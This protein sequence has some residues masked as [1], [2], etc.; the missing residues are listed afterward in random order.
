[1]IGLA[2]DANLLPSPRIRFILQSLSL[3]VFTY[4]FE[5]E[6]GPTR[7]YYLDLILNNLLLSCLFST[8]CLMIVING[9]NFIDGSNGL[10]LIYYIIILGIVSKL[11]LH[12]ELGI[13][14]NKLNYFC[15]FYYLYQF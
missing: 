7:I 6:V 12:L 1:M 4:I 8:F 15:Y 14:Q 13:Y 2:S 11:G 10:V 5:L 9:T 3:I